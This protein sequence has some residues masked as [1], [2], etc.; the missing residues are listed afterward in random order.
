MNEVV[1]DKIDELDVN[2]NL[3]YEIKN[4]VIEK[5]RAKYIRAKRPAEPKVKA[6]LKLN[7]KDK[8]PFHYAPS[9]LS[10]GEKNKVRAILDDLL[11]RGIIRPSIS[12]YAS[13]TVSVRKKDESI[14]LCIDFH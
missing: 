9:R 6:E 10:V 14:R 13:R 3:P 11:E 7:V 5:F 4:R 2:P 8:Q 12:E 1:S